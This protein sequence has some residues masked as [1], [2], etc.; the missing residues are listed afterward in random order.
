MAGIRDF[1]HIIV[2]LLELVAWVQAPGRG[3]SAVGDRGR[4]RRPVVRHHGAFGPAAVGPD[5]VCV[6]HQ[7][8]DVDEYPQQR[9]GDDYLARVQT[10]LA[11]EH[12]GGG[13][14]ERF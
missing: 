13:G 4:V 11:A 12:G 2:V 6:V 7:Y 9:R 3:H 14:Y 10:E 8:H 5:A 1:V